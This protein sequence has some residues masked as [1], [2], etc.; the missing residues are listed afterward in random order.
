MF[1]ITPVQHP[2]LEFKPTIE[3][4]ERYES[5]IDKDFN[6]NSED[7]RY[8]VFSRV[9]AGINFT[10]GKNVSGRIQYRY[11]HNWIWT[12]A[13]NYSTERTDVDQAYISIKDGQATVTLGRQ[14]IVKGDQKIIGAGQ[15]GNIAKSFDGVRF[16]NKSID[17]F[18][19]KMGTNSTLYPHS[20]LAYG[21]YTSPYGE[22]MLSYKQDEAAVKDLEAWTL[23]HRYEKPIGN[24]KIVAE[25]ALQIGHNQNKD[26]EAWM[27]S[28][29]VSYKVN[30][31]VSAFVAANIASGGG[32]SKVQR[33]FDQVYAALHAPFGAMDTTGLRNMQHIGCGFDLKPTK[34]LDMQLY[35]SILQLQDKTDAWYGSG[36]AINKTYSGGS[37]LDATG[38]RGRDLGQ[39]ID[40]TGN[41]QLTKELQL[42]FGVAMFMPG[43][44]VK[45]FQSGNHSDQYWSYVGITAKF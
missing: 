29:K 24:F 44:Y 6:S 38:S 18:V 25:G 35:Y 37:Y 28:A 32:S 39:E 1:L 10:Y 12:D 43:S 13:Q 41:Y 27:G 17:G 26:I 5:R 21:A 34:K 11:G 2:V 7:D 3:I 9:R 45:S 14:N 33:T 42:N 16:A 4:R 36:G 22:T 15:W 23:D 30:P 20:W 31:K 8:E 40:L 19:G